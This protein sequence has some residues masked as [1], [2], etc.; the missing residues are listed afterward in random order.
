MK[1][2]Y[3]LISVLLLALAVTQISSCGKISNPEPL[4]GS[5]YPHKYPRY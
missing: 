4:E 5:E 1:N 2:F 3:S